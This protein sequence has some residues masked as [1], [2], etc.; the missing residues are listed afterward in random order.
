MSRKAVRQ[1][2]FLY[3][4]FIVAQQRYYWF[5]FNID[6]LDSAIV[7][8][9][10]GQTDG[11]DYLIIFAKLIGMSINTNGYF[12]DT[13]GS[14]SVPWSIEKI[15]RD[16]KYFKIDQI[17][18]ALELFR[19]IGLIYDDN[20]I[21]RITEFESFVGSET[22]DAERMR[23][24]RQQNNNQSC[25]QLPKPKDNNNSYSS[26]ENTV[27]PTS[28]HQVE[29]D[30]FIVSEETDKQKSISFDEKKLSSRKS[31][32]ISSNTKKIASSGFYDEFLEKAYYE[33]EGRIKFIISEE[34]ERKKVV[35]EGG[36]MWWYSKPL[37]ERLLSI[38][39]EIVRHENYS[40]NG[41]L[42]S[43]SDIL[44][45][46]WNL[47]SSN[48]GEELYKTFYE[49]D[50]KV[51]KCIVTNKLLYSITALYNTAVTCVSF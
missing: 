8:Y 4:R 30:S 22:R 29:N 2:R 51:R 26:S 5:K 39:R 23:R 20:G 16:L 11:S 21:Y 25:K 47:V 18:V 12:K 44:D 43:S 17:R 45:L 14:L 48:D 19:T 9:I 10:M 6:F 49:I 50:E 34:D 40:I 7:D 24:R 35:Q 37:L 36:R 33:F 1:L 42:V 15:T 13:L 32:S 31:G 27:P 38:S 41:S 28:S 46:Y 3:V